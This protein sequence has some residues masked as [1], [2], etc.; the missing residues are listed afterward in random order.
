MKQF[1]FSAGLLAAS[2]LALSCSTTATRSEAQGE[3]ISQSSM[4]ATSAAPGDTT[5]MKSIVIDVRTQ[6]EWDQDGH[7]PCTKL[8]PLDQLEQRM[9]ELRSYEKIT[10]VC[11]S[12]ARAG[13]AAQM[14]KS[15]GFRNVQ[16]AGPWQN[17][18]CN[19]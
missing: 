15:K 10:I 16:N 13:N 11:R 3:P 8:I 12:G 17:A 7:A 4:A 9:E 14:L 1:L 2:L 18:P 19:E 6:G 5:P